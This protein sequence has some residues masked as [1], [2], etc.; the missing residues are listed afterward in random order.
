M[1]AA[2]RLPRRPDRRRHRRARGPGRR[3]GRRRDPGVQRR[4]PGPAAAADPTEASAVIVALRA[5]R[6]G[7]EDDTREVVDRAL[8]KLEAA[9]AEGGQRRGPDRPGRRRRRHRPGP[10]G[11]PAA[12][13]RATAAARSGSPTTCPR[14]D[15]Q[16][17]RVVDPRGRG[18]RRGARSTSTPGA[19]APRRRGCSG[20][21]GSTAPRCSTSPVETPQEG[22]RDLGRRHLQ[23]VHR[24]HARS[25]CCWSPRRAG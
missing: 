14:R 18:H 17:E 9:A 24:G 16:S 22:P 15:E 20:S 19:T 1:R 11:Q 4:L 25:R 5:L 10:A 2:G 8:A 12:E 7:A 6:N 23:P 13:R 21:T 3:P